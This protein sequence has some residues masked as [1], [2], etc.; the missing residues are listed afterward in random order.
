MEIPTSKNKYRDIVNK[1]HKMSHY[2]TQKHSQSS[3]KRV[4]SRE[5]PVRAPESGR[6][7]NYEQRRKSHRLIQKENLAMIDRLQS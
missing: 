2:G 7:L 1:T 4:H 5:G 6:S 3:L